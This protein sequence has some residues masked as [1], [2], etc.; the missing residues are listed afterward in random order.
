M[1]T[2]HYDL[3][4]VG[5]GIVGLGHAVA[6]L[7]RGLSVAVVDRASTIRGA[8]V[9]NFGHLCL[10]GQEGEARAYA[11]LARELWLTLAPEVGF[12]LRES[13]TVVVAQADDELAV[14][15]EFRERRGGHNV[16]MLT[17]DEVRERVPVGPGVAIGGAFLPHDLQV[18]PREASLAIARWLDAHGVDFFWQTAVVG[19]ET[20]AVHTTRGRVSADAVVV[21]VNA[22][23]D[24]LFPGIAEAAGIRRC[25]LDMMLVDADLDHPLSA[26]LFTGWSLIRYSGFA[27]TPSAAGLR[28]RLAEE[29]PEL[30]ALDLNQMYTQRPDGSLIVGDTHYRGD[31]V[32]P[33]QREAA[34]DALLDQARLLFGTDRIRVRERWQGVYASAPDEFLLASPAPQVR[35]VSVTTGIGMTTG[36]GFAERV[37]DDLF[38]SSSSALATVGAARD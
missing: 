14:L 2:K 13:G 20:G 1:G 36:L 5:S 10:T 30:L 29:H 16:R 11:E 22:D 21:A 23:V 28:D 6:A 38:S 12:W 35:V 34:F 37:V 8:S 3:A 32:P 33:F 26:P 31:D 17:A 24:Q 27:R 4:I 7:R 15:A 18:D 19:V 9:R 25:G